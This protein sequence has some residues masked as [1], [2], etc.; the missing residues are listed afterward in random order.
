MYRC[1]LFNLIS[2][3]N[4]QTCVVQVRRLGY[5][6][7]AQW[8][9]ADSVQRGGTKT[10]RLNIMANKSG[11]HKLS[12]SAQDATARIKRVSIEGNIGK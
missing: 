10:V 5:N 2:T 1:V 4:I 7:S 6:I 8:M 11:I 12:S 3:L 9:A